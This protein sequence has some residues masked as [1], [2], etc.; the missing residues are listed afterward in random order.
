MSELINKIQLKMSR[1]TFLKGSAAAT[2][3]LAVLSLA[4]CQSLEETEAS[5]TT[6]ETGASTEASTEAPIEHTP[7]D[8]PEKNGTWVAAA[9]WHNCGGRC[10]NKALVVDGICIRQ[11][12]DDTHEDSPQYPQQRACVRGRAQQQQCFG[13]DRLKYPMKRKNWE[14]GGENING[15]LRG[16]DEWERI[17]WD[18][19]FEMAASEIKRIYDT[20]GANSVMGRGGNYGLKVLAAMGGYSSIADTTSFGTYMLDTTKLGL[21]IEDLGKANDRFDLK[22]SDT[23]VLYGCNPAWA[24]GGSPPYHLWQAKEAGTEYVVVGPSFNASAQYLEAKWIRVRPGTDTAF[25]LAVA[26]EMLKLDEE[27]GDIIDWDFLNTY[28]VGFDRDHLPEDAVLDECFKE[29]VLGDYDGIPKTAEWAEEICGTPAEDIRWYAKLMGKSNKVALLHSYSHARNHNAEDIPQLFMT[30]GAMGA[31]FGKSGHACGSI[32]HSAAANGGPSLVK[33]GA[34]GVSNIPNQVDDRLIG[35]N[36]W[37]TILEG[38]YRYIGDYY[39]NVFAE[40]E[41]RDIDIRMI[42]HES[43]ARLQASPDLMNGIKVHRKVDFVLTHAQFLTTQAKYSDLVLPVTTEWERIGSFQTGNR[44]AIFVNSQVTEP[45]YESKTDQEIAAGIA[46]A[47]G[48][49]AEEIFPLSEKQQFFNQILGST[50]INEAG[51][52][53][54]PLVTVTQQD[55]DEWEC[56]GEPQEGVIGLKELLEKGVYQVERKEGDPYGFIGYEDFI[57]DPEVN[58]LPST[59]G[60]FEIYCQWKGDILNGF[61]L[62][63]EFKPYPTYTV[64]VEGYETTFADWEA[65][66]KGE[67][68]YIVY[69]PHYFRRSHTVFD[70]V[71]WLRETWPNPVYL[72]AKDAEEKGIKTGDTVL[73]YN[74]YGKILR[75]ASVLEIIMPGCVGVPHGAWIDLDEESGIDLGG[76]DNCLCGHSL[77]GMGVTGYNNYNCNFQKYDGDPLVPDCEKPQRIVEL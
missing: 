56:E 8:D 29:Y 68:P 71:P 17:S 15:E 27:T 62:G 26:Y 67:Y 53:Y 18:E 19:A 37:K 54:V 9:C 61:G 60:K 42:Y 22:N 12:T 24:S 16:I 51:T 70:N 77:S 7:L 58:P 6:K 44:E 4:G 23:I 41:D 28:T 55:I 38:K 32:Y 59:S 35:P 49:N 39:A 52:D 5:E 3:A 45:L 30:I 43:A 50:V 20:Y 48:L 69:N 75:T 21:P 14:P 66:E 57:K 64:P 10:L 73:V 65:K 72:S 2:A 46:K 31:H 40:G 13:A 34:S 76:S 74:Q 33:P 47:L 36:M 1:R 11:K 25:L 63:S